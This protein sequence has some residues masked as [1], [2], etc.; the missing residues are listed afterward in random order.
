MSARDSWFRWNSIGGRSVSYEE[1]DIRLTSRIQ[2]GTEPFCFNAY[3]CAFW[4]FVLFFLFI[5]LYFFT[6]MI[7]IIV[8]VVFLWSFFFDCCC[9]WCCLA[10]H[11]SV[12]L[13]VYFLLYLVA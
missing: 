10:C 3:V 4:S 11:S 6:V 7:I 1:C 9:H 2:L 8:V 13:Q 12:C 5:F